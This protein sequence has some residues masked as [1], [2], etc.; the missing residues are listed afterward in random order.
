[1]A[2]VLAECAGVP[3]TRLRAG[4][5]RKLLSH[6]SK[7]PETLPGD[8]EKKT[9]PFVMAEMGARHRQT[10]FSATQKRTARKRLSGNLANNHLY[11]LVL[12]RLCREC[13]RPSVSKASASSCVNTDVAC[14]LTR[15]LYAHSLAASSCHKVII[16]PSC[17]QRCG[18]L[19]MPLTHADCH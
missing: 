7:P 10:V 4:S 5:R 6:P 19:T 17:M 14:L 11:R 16:I 9:R 12:S 15:R 1:M 2:R 13:I 18:C 3:K 8:G